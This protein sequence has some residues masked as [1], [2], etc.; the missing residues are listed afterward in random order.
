MKKKITKATKQAFWSKKLQADE[1]HKCLRETWTNKAIA[2][3]RHKHDNVFKVNKGN[4]PLLMAEWTIWSIRL[5]LP[6]TPIAV[7]NNNKQ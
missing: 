6:C 3:K 7:H 2:S 1:I 4:C 5:T